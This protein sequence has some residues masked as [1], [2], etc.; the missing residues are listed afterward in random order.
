M[1]SRT[2]HDLLIGMKSSIEHLTGDFREMHRNIGA[3]AQSLTSLTLAID[4]KI[5]A[6]VK[7]K[8]DTV[9]HERHVAEDEKIHETIIKDLDFLKKYAWLALGALTVIEIFFRFISR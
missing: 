6:A 8:V 2:D 4:A 7:M 1:L 3:L 9:T 5:A